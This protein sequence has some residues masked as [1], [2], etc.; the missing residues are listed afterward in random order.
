MYS[1]IYCYMYAFDSVYVYIHNNTINVG[2]IRKYY[3]KYVHIYIYIYTHV[4]ERRY[5]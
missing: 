3:I 4:C 2:N 5:V 1:L